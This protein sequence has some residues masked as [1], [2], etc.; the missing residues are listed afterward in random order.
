MPSSDHLKSDGSNSL[1]S[2][3]KVW[4]G[5]NFIMS[6][7][8]D[9]SQYLSIC[10]LSILHSLLKWFITCFEWR[11]KV[12]PASASQMY[13]SAVQ[14]SGVPVSSRKETFCQS[15]MSRKMTLG[16]TPVKSSLVALWS[17]GRLNSWWPVSLQEKQTPKNK[18]C[19]CTY[20]ITNFLQ[21]NLFS[22]LYH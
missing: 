13:R 21:N 8:L 2:R 18:V 1:W 5:L 14:S 15:R 22:K 9:S 11:F 7:L 3:G 20:R 17:G 16:I 6:G 4:E 12:W 10:L 19:F